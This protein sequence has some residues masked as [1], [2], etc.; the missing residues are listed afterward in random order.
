MSKEKLD[1]SNRCPWAKLSNPLYVAYHDEEWG[2]PVHD[3]TKLFEMIILEGAQAGLS[4]ESILNRREGYRKAFDNFDLQK[5]IKWTPEKR[6]SLRNDPGIIRNRLKIESV[7]INARAFM[8]VQ[9]EFGSFDNYLWKFVEGKQ[10]V[11]SP[12]SMSD[13]SA[14]TEISDKLAKDLKKRGFKFMGSTIVYAFMQAIGM[15]NDHLLSC[16]CRRL[17]K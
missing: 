12:E 17:N 16:S 2:I 5:I 8:K 3:D 4:W 6:E 9:K 13:I 7:P 1:V 14:T 10:I 15:V 11:N